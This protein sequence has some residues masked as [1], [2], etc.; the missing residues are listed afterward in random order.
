MQNYMNS[1]ELHLL[2]GNDD[3]DDASM[4]MVRL[5]LAQAGYFHITKNNYCQYAIKYLNIK[6]LILSNKNITVKFEYCV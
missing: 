5:N 3:D 6:K 2:P 4:A 1:V